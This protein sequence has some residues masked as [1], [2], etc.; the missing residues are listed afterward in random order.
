MTYV[1]W[2]KISDSS[3]LLSSVFVSSPREIPRLLSFYLKI[4]NL[5]VCRKSSQNFLL[6]LYRSSRPDLF[7]KKVV[8]KSFCKSY[9]KTHLSESLFERSWR[10][11][12]CKFCKIFENIFFYRTSLVAASAAC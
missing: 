10:P 4:D 3:M 11:E 8:L 6:Y 5:N 1:G 9:R 7:C 2:D 12:A